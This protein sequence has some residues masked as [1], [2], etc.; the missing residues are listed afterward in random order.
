MLYITLDKEHNIAKAV[1]SIIAIKIPEKILKREARADKIKS[2]V[3]INSKS[4]FKTT[5]GPG[6]S[7]GIS[8]IKEIICQTD[9]Q[10][11]VIEATFNAFNENFLKF[12]I[13]YSKTH[14]H[15]I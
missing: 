6:K 13:N 8:I 1:P 2:F 3:T 5:I 9:N 11:N 15:L 12:T 10:S 4:L 14:L 7:S